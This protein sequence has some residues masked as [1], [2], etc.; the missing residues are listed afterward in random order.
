MGKA[1]GNEVMSVAQ[2]AGAGHTFQLA[3]PMPWLG[4]GRAIGGHSQAGQRQRPRPARMTSVIQHWQYRSALVEAVC[5]GL[6][7]VVCCNKPCSQ[8]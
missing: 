6:T 8:C 5:S 3:T 1:G 4:G 2:E 7:T